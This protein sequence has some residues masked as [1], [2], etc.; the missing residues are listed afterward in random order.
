[1]AKYIGNY[2]LDARPDRIDLRDRTYEPPLKS[3]GAESPPGDYVEKYFRMYKGLVLDQGTEGACTGFGLACTIN[4]LLWRRTVI[5]RK[6]NKQLKKSD[7]PAKVSQRMLYH[8]ARFYDEW[9]GEDYEGSSCRGAVKAWH[10]HGVCSLNLWP[11]TDENGKVVFVK[12]K[13]GWEEDAAER[14]LGVY[15]RIDK[16]SIT[17]MQVAI[18]EVGAI[19]VSGQVHDGWNLKKNKAKT[20]S[21]GTLPRIEWQTDTPQ[22]GGHAFAL[23]GFNRRGFIVQNSWG[24]D[25]GL[26]GFAIL[27][28]D[29]WN[30]NGRDAWVCVMGA[31]TE[32][33]T[34]THF[35]LSSID[36]EQSLF[37]AD[38][39]TFELFR[40]KAQDHQYQN[41][42]IKPWNEEKSYQHSVVM[43]NDGKVIN[44]L[45]INDGPVDTVDDIVERRVEQWLKQKAGPEHHIVIYAHGGLN[46][47]SDSVKRIQTLA[48]YFLENG[49]YPLFLTWKT[50]LLESIVATMD[51]S[52][53]RLFPRS[54]GISDVLDKAKEKVTEILDRTLEVAS[55][56][57][58]VKAIWSQMKQNASASAL[59]GD[60]DRGS[61]LAVKALARLKK[62]HPGLKIHLIG[63]SA[64]SILLGHLLQDCPRNG[65]RIASCT[66]YAAACTVDFANRHYIRAVEKSTLAK[67]NIH[68]HLLSDQREKDDTVGP[69]QKSLLYLVSRAL[70]NWHK[71]PLLGMANVFDKSLNDNKIWNRNT[72][73]HIKR[74]Q[75]FWDNQSLNIHD[76]EQVTT[77]ALWKNGKIDK[78]IARIDAAHGSFDNDIKVIDQTIQRITGKPLQQNVE[79]L[80]Y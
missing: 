20:I 18:Q 74:W 30:A 29:D 66:L 39:A 28:Y 8:L 37:D 77:A 57:L 58:G 14:P 51:D 61:F 24:P 33:R 7:L 43:S 45:V 19:Y 48:P 55:E 60:N 12:P 1:M 38:P 16:K 34:R 21:H 54:E 9:P 46:S 41:P 13:D 42:V 80:R 65:L 70:E 76:D 26:K 11:Y 49:V 10:K 52:V 27:S 67:K 2:Q 50:G 63:H 56:N 17:D 44:R 23:V 32:S 78:E 4:Y 75:T 5:G 79:N 3:L 25:W 6:E 62:K 59:K 72:L 53:S 64:G 71:T 68:L 35:V 69:Y 15:Y 73:P 40:K 47:E 22:Q 31:P 36:R